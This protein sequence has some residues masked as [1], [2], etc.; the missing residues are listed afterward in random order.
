MSSMR[1]KKK[2]QGSRPREG[3]KI[4]RILVLVGI[5]RGL[6]WDYIGVILRVYLDNG[7]ENGSYYG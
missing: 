4:G 6:C 5:Y 2:N 1:G 7:K 3:P